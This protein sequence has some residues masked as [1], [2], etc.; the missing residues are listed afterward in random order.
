MPPYK[1]YPRR[2]V[3]R[4]IFPVVFP[5][6]SKRE[7]ILSIIVDDIDI[8]STGGLEITLRDRKVRDRIHLLEFKK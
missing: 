2:D 3:C 8:L 6:L 5:F 1:L 7:L 4:D